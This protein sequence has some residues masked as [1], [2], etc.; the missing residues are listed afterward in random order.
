MISSKKLSISFFI[1]IL[2]SIFLLPHF[3]II[4]NFPGIRID[5]ILLPF[6]IAYMVINKKNFINNH[7]KIIFLFIICITIS[8]IVNNRLG[9]YRDYYEILKVLKF[10]IYILFFS[11]LYIE[12]NYLYKLFKFIFIIVCIFN[13]FQYFNI[14]SFN[15]IIEI[16]YSPSHHLAFHGLDSAGNKATIRLLGTM[17]NPNNNAILFLFFIIF[18]MPKSISDPKETKYLY[19]IAILGSMYSQSRTAFIILVIVLIIHLV[20][21]FSIIKKHYIV[22]S[23]FFLLLLVNLKYG[24]LAYLNSLKESKVAINEAS[25][26]D[27]AH[28]NKARRDGRSTNRDDVSKVSQ[29]TN[30]IGEKMKETENQ[31]FLLKTNNSSLQVRFEIW[32]RLITMIKQKPLLGHG[33]NK[34]YFYNNE[35]YAEN[36]Y[37][38]IT[39]RYG[40]IGLFVFLAMILSPLILSFK[41]IKSDEY[42][43]LSLY[44]LVIIITAFTNTPLSEPSLLLLLA[45]FIG[46]LF[47]KINIEKKNEKEAFVNF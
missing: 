21:K 11:T 35:L 23:C 38:L 36:E 24:D 31:S 9:Y 19:F 44:I 42:M 16:Y 5:D 29:D 32:Q 1:I 13:I 33:P 20:L 8:I 43:Q 46:R 28:I 30:L 37:V 10:A 26:I 27:E 3:K 14:F 12:E 40:L 45:F 2:F 15:E 47:L 6:I 34:E 17:G 39:W 4:E 7:I 18:F 41:F 22:F 25:D